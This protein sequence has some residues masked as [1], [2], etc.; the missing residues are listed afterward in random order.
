MRHSRSGLA[1]ITLGLFAQA[2][3]AQSGGKQE[4]LHRIFV[5]W[6]HRQGLLKTVRYVI[7]GTIEYKDADKR[8]PSESPVRPRRAVLLLDLEHKRW[9]VQSS[10][11]D[12]SAGGGKGL[13]YV[14]MVATAA[15]DGTALQTYYHREE[16]H[17]QGDGPDLVIEKGQ[18]HRGGAFDHNLYPVF[19]AHGIVATVYDTQLQAYDLPTTYDSDNFEVRGRLPF[20]GRNCSVIRTLSLPMSA[21]FYDEF[22]IDTSQISAVYRHVQFSGPEPVIRTDIDWKQTDFGPWPSQWTV[23]WMMNGRLHRLHRLRVESFEPNPPVT[24]GDFKLEARPGMKVVV[25]DAPPPGPGMNP[26]FVPTKTYVVSASGSWHEIAARGYTAL[27]GKIVPLERSRAWV[28]CT[29]AVA[30]TT[31]IALG[32]YRVLRRHHSR[33][34]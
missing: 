29:V 30:L 33:R 23:A 34:D 19:F 17:L 8:L 4:V 10:Q 15:F 32:A 11:Q 9:R 16:N 31:G 12:L 22:W 1:V 3:L 7:P 27:D 14:T 20:R 28:W 13:S 26:D 24:D 25:A 5:D 2:G 21:A 18:L 6:Q